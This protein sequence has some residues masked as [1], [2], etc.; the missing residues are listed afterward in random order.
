MNAQ[1]D[2]HAHTF[3]NHRLPAA[4]LF[5]MD[6]TLIDSE[7]LWLEAE[8]AVTREHGVDWSEHDTARVFGIPLLEA[9]AAMIGK[10][11]PGTPE[12][13]ADILVDRVGAALK[14]HCPWLPGARELLAALGDAGIPCA[15]VSS[16]FRPLVDITV[17]AA[18]R[19]FA[20]SVAGDETERCKPAPDPYLAAAA[21]IGADIR[22][23]VVVEDSAGGMT[24]GLASGAAVLLVGQRSAELAQSARAGDPD[25]RVSARPGLDAITPGMLAAL[26]G[27]G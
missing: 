21:D 27:S 25:A 3:V 26:V 19:R 20:A 15:L 6:G 7:R 5:D 23:C 14:Q 9:T 16:S 8:I 13:L 18:P 1:V 10:G 4:V 22:D 2:V 24:A 11:M 12:E 17:A